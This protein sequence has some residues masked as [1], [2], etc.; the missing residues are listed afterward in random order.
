[1][2]L[3][4]LFAVVGAVVVAVVVD[5]VVCAVVWSPWEDCLNKLLLMLS[6]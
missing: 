4:S 5:V 3:F 6:C 2:L 1:M